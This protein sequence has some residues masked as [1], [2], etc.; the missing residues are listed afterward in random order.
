MHGA[1]LRAAHEGSQPDKTEAAQGH[2]RI[3]RVQNRPGPGIVDIHQEDRAERLVVGFP[4]GVDRREGAEG[5][6]DLDGPVLH[7][8]VWGQTRCV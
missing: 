3:H 6:L 5:G 4:E 8:A 7:L 2:R 1:A